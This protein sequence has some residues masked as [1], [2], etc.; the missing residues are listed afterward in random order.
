M[1][2]TQQLTAIISIDNFVQNWI[3]N[4]FFCDLPIYRKP[5]DNVVYNFKQRYM[6][7]ISTNY[8]PQVSEK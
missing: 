5:L 4:S 6:L 7:L 3:K 8:S 2:T 1:P